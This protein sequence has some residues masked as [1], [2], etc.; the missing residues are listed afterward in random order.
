MLRN[1]KRWAGYGKEESL[2]KCKAQ[3]VCQ[4]KANVAVG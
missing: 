2:K 4:P 1:G 3:T